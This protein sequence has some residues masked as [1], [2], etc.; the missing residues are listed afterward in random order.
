LHA[1]NKLWKLNLP[2]ADLARIARRLGAD[3]PVCAYGASAWMTGAGEAFAPIETPPF[4]AVLVNPLRP[5][6]T[7]DV[8]REFDRMGLGSELRGS[9]PT[10]Q[11]RA[12]ALAAITAI[13]NDLE[14]PARALMPDIEAIA[15][16]L[17]SEPRVEYAA[18]SG[19][20]ATMFAL[21]ADRMA[22]DALAAHLSRLRAAWWIRAT[23]LSVAA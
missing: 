15:T 4:A 5:L 11:D 12:A 9:A 20:G 16:F 23:Q 19:S 18:L 10:L 6:A 8:Y 7:A 3:V 13:G 21:V 2:V 14:A 22:A 17:K 1:L